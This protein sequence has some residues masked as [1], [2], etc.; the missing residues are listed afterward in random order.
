MLQKLLE[1]VY[2]AEG[3][4][5]AAD[6]ARRLH[7]DEALVRAM[8][9]QLEHLGYLAEAGPACGADC[10]ACSEKCS[11][12]SPASPMKLLLLTPAGLRALGKG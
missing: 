5:H 3:S 11:A 12:C 4:T 8:L 6:L 7:V 2:G 9:A 1:A 10:A